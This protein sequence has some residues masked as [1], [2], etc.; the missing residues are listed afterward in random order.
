[1]IQDMRSFLSE[2]STVVL[3]LRTIRC[4]VA[5]VE[6]PQGPTEQSV[7]VLTE[8]VGPGMSIRHQVPSPCAELG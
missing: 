4:R 5:Q 2:Y 8:V 7:L 6:Y 3:A 1:M